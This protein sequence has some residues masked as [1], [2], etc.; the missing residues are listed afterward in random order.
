MVL[1]TVVVAE[2]ALDVVTGSFP[3]LLTVSLLLKQCLLIGNVY[4]W[5]LLVSPCHFG[6]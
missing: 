3:V 6:K 5:A 2:G 1:G 4:V